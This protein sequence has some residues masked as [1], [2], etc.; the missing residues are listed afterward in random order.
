MLVSA[1]AAVALASLATWIGL[2]PAP[3]PPS[4]HLEAVADPGLSPFST[5][6][7]HDR[8]DVIPPANVAGEQRGD[9]PGLYGQAGDACA[10]DALVAALRRDNRAA[11]WARAEGRSDDNAEAAINTLTPLVLRTDVLVTEHGWSGGATSTY[12]AV[13]QAGSAVLVD[14]RGVPRARCAN[15]NPLGPP[16][17]ALGTDFTG[18]PWRWFSPSAVTLVTETDQP[19]ASIVALDLDSGTTVEVSTQH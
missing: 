6:V 9:T 2:Q 15:G 10:P 1:A 5:G 19:L 4:V 17:V 7:G 18:T 8:D 11:A 12:P 16:D 14:E 13:V 3:I